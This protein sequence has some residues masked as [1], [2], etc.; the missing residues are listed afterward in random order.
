MGWEDHA[1]EQYCYLTTTGRTT[2]QPREIEIWFGIANATL[3]MLSGSGG[4]AGH[5]KAHWVR[6]LLKNPLVTVRI[7]EDTFTGRARLT[8]PGTDEDAVARRLLV[9]KYQPGYANDLSNW[10]RTALPVAVE[11]SV[12]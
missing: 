4:D 9:E 1:G 12:P 3:Y 5:P 6:N 7:A 2:G 10:G 11:L 8:E